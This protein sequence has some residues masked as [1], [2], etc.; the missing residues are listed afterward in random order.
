[1]ERVIVEEQAPPR[2]LRARWLGRVAY[3]EAWAEWESG[4]DAAVWESSVGDGLD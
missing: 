3:R 4:G 2:L 1:M